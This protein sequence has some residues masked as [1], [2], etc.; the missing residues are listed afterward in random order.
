MTTTM[1]S[2]Y[3][4]AAHNS[5]PTALAHHLGSSTAPAHHNSDE[6]HPNPNHNANRKWT[7]MNAQCQGCPPPH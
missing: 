4:P 1:P 2:H 6:Q 5:L 7:L 3:P